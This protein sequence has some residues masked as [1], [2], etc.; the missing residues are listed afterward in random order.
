MKKIIDNSLPYLTDL[1]NADKEMIRI[2]TMNENYEV[3]NFHDIGHHSS[4]K[5][6]LF[7]LDSIHEV[8]NQD[9]VKGFVLVHNHPGGQ[10]FPSDD[11]MQVTYAVVQE[12]KHHEKNF[13]DHIIITKD[14]YYSFHETFEEVD[15]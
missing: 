7:N 12:F 3:I 9:N 14:N 11:D 15:N 10:N 4:R 13:L 6:V 2:I 1:R 8:L 5:D